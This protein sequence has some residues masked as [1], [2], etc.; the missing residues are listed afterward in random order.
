MQ[1]NLK[2]PG[3]LNVV[4]R[5]LP[6]GTLPVSH[7]VL[8]LVEVCTEPSSLRHVIVVPRAIVRVLGENDI[9]FIAIVFGGIVPGVEPVPYGFD[10]SPEHP[11]AAAKR[12]AAIP[13]ISIFVLR[14]IEPSS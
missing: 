10:E 7:P 14:F 6:D 5:E 12:K 9:A 4:V 2:I 11:A 1:W 13:V 8:S 3:V